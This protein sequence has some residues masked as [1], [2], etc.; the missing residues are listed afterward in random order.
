MTLLRF[1]TAGESH[2][3]ALLGILEGM[4]AGLVLSEGDIDHELKRRQK[5]AGSGER[6]SIE[7]D[8]CTL[9]SGVM[10]GKTTG[11]PIAIQI[12]NRD[13]AN[14]QGMAIEA[15]TIPRPGHVDLA[16][17]IKY[18]YDD[19]RPG[20]ERASARETAARVAIG[21]ICKSFLSSFNIIIG[22]YVQS[23][24]TTD[25]MIEDISD[26]DRL[27]LAE[28]N[29]LRCPNIKS[30]ALMLKEIEEAKQSGETLGG[31]IEVVCLGIPSGLGSHVHWDRK[32]DGRLAQAVMSIPAIKGIEIGPAFD[33]T[34]KQGTKVQDEIKI[35]NGKLNRDTNSAGGLE[36][37]ITNGQP[38]IIRAAMKPIP[39]TLKPQMSTD[40]VSGEARQMNY[41]RSDICPV[42]RAV[43]VVEAMA[44]F[45][46][47]QAFLEKFGGDSMEE[48]QRKID[49]M[50]NSSLSS[51]SVN[52]NK[53]K[54][55]PA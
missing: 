38:V 53:K 2:G 40:L 12:I 22:G 35:K 23:I 25:A 47:A 30:A 52:D 37:G 17:A 21:A 33:N 51:F 50:N 28:D 13:H 39:T 6:M 19:L 16:A 45:I 41:E 15:R 7:D 42:P 49:H 46:I 36:G 48:I 32:L 20:F 8:R 18:G 31:V 44:A 54:W 5:G 27:R 11:A 43:V 34:K 26:L 14:W 10:D 29:N 55:W 1:L 4:P 9:L 3:P 24:G